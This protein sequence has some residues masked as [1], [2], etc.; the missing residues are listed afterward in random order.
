MNIGDDGNNRH[1]QV[2][3]TKKLF[4]LK[5]L[6]SHSTL[7]HVLKQNIQKIYTVPK[8]FELKEQNI[9]V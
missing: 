9:I 5:I 1:R 7:V 3:E 8:T 2:T 4:G 6:S